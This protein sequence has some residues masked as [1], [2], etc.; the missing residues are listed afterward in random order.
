MV[1]AGPSTRN[2]TMTSNRLIVVHLQR[3]AAMKKNERVYITDIA[4]ELGMNPKTARA[5]LRA[6]G[7]STPYKLK[8][9][10]K[11]IA[12]LKR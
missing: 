10:A 1:A 6:A 3:G 7:F 5:K 2:L 11:L 4:R 8:D 12:C 9:R